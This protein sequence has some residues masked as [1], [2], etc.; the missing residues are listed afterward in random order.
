[1][2]VICMQL[3]KEVNLIQNSPTE[4]KCVA[5][6]NHCEKRYDIQDGG[7]E[8]SVMVYKLMAKILMMMIQ[9]NLVLNSRE[10]N[11]NSP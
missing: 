8:M 2:M 9:V 10:G 1:M 7:P 11:K 6:R 3:Q 5:L 4:K